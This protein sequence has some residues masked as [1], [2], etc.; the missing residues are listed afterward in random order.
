MLTQIKRKL[1]SYVNFRNI[2]FKTRK[3]IRD[4]EG[5][6]ILTKGSFLQE[7][8]TILN[9]YKPNKSINLRD[10]KTYRSKGRVKFTIK[11]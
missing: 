5:Y 6:Y 7:D 9:V 11:S 8:T 1:S 4:K 3:N 2:V 10:A